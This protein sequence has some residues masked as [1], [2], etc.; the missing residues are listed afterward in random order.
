MEEQVDIPALFAEQI[1]NK[2]DIALGFCIYNEKNSYQYQKFQLIKELT[3]LVSELLDKDDIRDRLIKLANTSKVNGDDNDIKIATFDLI[4]NILIHF[5]IF[6]TWDEI[7]ISES[8]LKWNNPKNSN[9][10]KYFKNN[11]NKTFTY[12]ILLNE[13]KKWV[14]RHTIKIT[15]PVLEKDKKVYLKDFLSLDDAIWTFGILD[16]YLKD[17]G[18]NITPYCFTCSL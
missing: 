14:E 4:R 15:I 9:I 10:L 3:P 1:K 17:L 18:L 6:Q 16:Y 5:P 8:L 7:W 13:N 2:I 12:R 11:C